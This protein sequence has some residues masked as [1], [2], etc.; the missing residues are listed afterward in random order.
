[1]LCLDHDSFMDTTAVI[2]IPDDDRML[3]NFAFPPRSYGLISPSLK[4]SIR[5][6]VAG[7]GALSSIHAMLVQMD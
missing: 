4:R 2:Q 7:H 5:E 3:E 1:M 6:T